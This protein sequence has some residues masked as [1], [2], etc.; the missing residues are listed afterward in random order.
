[1]D[2][3]CNHPGVRFDNKVRIKV[4]SVKRV[5][6]TKLHKITP[7]SRIDCGK[8][9]G[10]SL[11]I[12]RPLRIIWTHGDSDDTIQYPHYPGHGK[13]EDMAMQTMRCCLIV[14]V[15]VL[16]CPIKSSVISN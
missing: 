1:M 5:E 9:G 3:G 16:M 2:T 4:I 15:M 13:N 14:G 11:A 7:F 6:Q 10:E 8:E 12:R